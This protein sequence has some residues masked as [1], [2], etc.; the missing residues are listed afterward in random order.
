ME[1]KRKI[2]LKLK[3][4]REV[5]K[6]SLLGMDKKGICEEYGINAQS[7]IR[8]VKENEELVNL[9]NE[10]P[11]LETKYR[12]IVSKDKKMQEINIKELKSIQFFDIT[13]GI[14]DKNKQCYF[15]ICLVLTYISAPFL[16]LQKIF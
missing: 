15:F 8:I 12:R 6:L 16:K 7:I 10:D 14:P 5:V 13:F 2:G 1:R 11:A 4:K 9:N 3:D